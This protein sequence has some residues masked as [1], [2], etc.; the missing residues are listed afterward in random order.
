MN[1]N[2]WDSGLNDILPSFC[3]RL[4]IFDKSNKEL[5]KTLRTVSSLSV[6][7]Y[8]HSIIS[9]DYFW[10]NLVAR[11]GA[12]ALLLESLPTAI[13][14]QWIDFLK[15]EISQIPIVEK[16]LYDMKTSN[17]FLVKDNSEIE[18]FSILEKNTEIFSLKDESF[19]ELKTSNGETFNNYKRSC[20]A[21]SDK[22]IA[23]DNG[24][25]FISIFTRGNRKLLLTL[26][27]KQKIWQMEIRDDHLYIR[28]GEPHNQ[29]LTIYNLTSLNLENEIALPIQIFFFWDHRHNLCFGTT[30]L[31][32]C[33]EVKD[34]MYKLCVASYEDL[35]KLP[36]NKESV[37]T[38]LEDSF[39]TIPRLSVQG[40]S[41]FAVTLEETKTFSIKEINIANGTITL[42]TLANKISILNPKIKSELTFDT[43]LYTNGRLIVGYNEDSTNKISSY[44]IEKKRVKLVHSQK[45][46][47]LCNSPLPYQI[48]STTA[49]KIDCLKVKVVDGWKLSRI[50]LNFGNP[51]L[52]I[53]NTVEFWNVSKSD[54]QLGSFKY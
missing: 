20:G 34:Q 48:I 54:L 16:R 1:V 17:S 8:F 33:S 4:Q 6:N 45:G 22:F 23:I 37:F 13:E 19:A 49:L 15:R 41:F 35:K 5:F 39:S 42:K 18:L 50:S 21:S 3:Y 53:P 43:L 14:G 26:K 29:T 27:Y 51:K 11:I 12:Q 36:D 40:N 2:S 24:V 52:Q 10:R 7:R 38:W 30:H 44:D 47:I 25:S 32:G 9:S 31:I 28:S 46:S